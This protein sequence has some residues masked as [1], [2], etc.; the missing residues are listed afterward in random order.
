M[1]VSCP[2]CG[3]GYDV[4]L[5][6]FGRTLSCACGERVGCALH[7][8]FAAGP[9]PRF[10]ADAM[11]GRLARWLRV[12]GYDTAYDA[13]ADDP[14][15]VQRAVREGRVLLT[16]DRRL[17]QEWWIDAVIVLQ[18]NTPLAQLSE[19]GT[20]LPLDPQR[21]LFTRCTLCNALL[22]PATLDAVR[23]LLPARVVA[24][25]QRFARCP[26][27]RRVYWEGSHT[28]RMRRLLHAALADGAPVAARERA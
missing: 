23:E 15:V 26:D 17:P 25:Q 6:Q 1:S 24:E 18:A 5:F 11:L 10:V 3:R 9:E 14:Q 28:Q 27:C 4:A 8:A 13:G 16:R 2:R 19:L 21:R 7:R 20:R 12:L 22:E